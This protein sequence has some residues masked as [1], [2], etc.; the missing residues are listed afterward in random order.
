MS[1]I[2]DW[3]TDANAN[4]AGSPDG[5]PEGMSRS[6]VNDSDRETQAAVKRNYDAPDFRRP[7][8]DYTFSRITGTQFHL[9]D[10]VVESNASL[11]LEPGQRIRMI[12]GGTDAGK[13]WEGFV[14]S[15]PTPP[16]YVAP[17]TGFFV[18]WSA[19]DSFDTTGPTVL[20][21]YM[22]VS[23]KEL[24]Q[25]AWYDTGAASGQLPLFDD[26]D[27]H[28]IKPE[29]T[30]DVGFLEGATRE[31]IEMAAARGRLNCNG[32]FD[33]WQ[34]AT[35]Y[36]G[37][38]SYNNAVGNSLADN[39]TATQE[40]SDTCDFE[41]SSEVPTDSGL[42]YSMRMTQVTANRKPGLITTVEVKDVQDVA[43]SGTTQRISVSFWLKQ[44]TITGIDDIR[45]DVLIFN[46]ER[47]SIDVVQPTGWNAGGSGVD[48]LYETSQWN[49][50]PGAK[51][52][53]SITTSWQRFVI[54]DIDV[55]TAPSGT[56]GLAIHFWAD[57]ATIAAGAQWHVT[58]VQIN[59]G[60]KALPFIRMPR[61]VEFAWCQRY[62]EK[63]MDEDVD[64]L[65]NAGDE[66]ALLALCSNNSAATTWNFAVEKFRRPDVQTLNPG[67]GTSLQ[68]S[69]GT[70]DIPAVTDRNKSQAQIWF[71]SGGTNGNLYRIAASAA[72]N[73]YGAG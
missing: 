42:V 60:P 7:F 20:P 50:I 54:E 18:D 17:I 63:T 58:G 12:G 66:H 27:P 69:D 28:V 9:T 13:T 40:L 23:F 8:E 29:N 4:S 67:S 62:F 21:S 24:G 36:V 48:L 43:A 72:A 26:L 5:Y 11:L 6:G 44:G 10:G 47:P 22:E 45:A 49:L 57:E 15:T 39:W 53:C 64:P 14:A 31:D 55:D 61:E 56:R 70:I 46:Q 1:D 25:A 51:L 68:W 32:G 71:A 3:F 2:K 34:R 19:A 59:R 52:D 65:D 73:V 16:N 37:G 33:F 30:L 41:R 35:S 38:A